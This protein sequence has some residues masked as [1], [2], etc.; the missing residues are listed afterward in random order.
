MSNIFFKPIK[1]RLDFG[2]SNN[3]VTE[4]KTP[5]FSWGAEHSG[6]NQ[7]QS[8]YK[9]EITCEDKVLFMSG[10]VKSDAQKHFCDDVDFESSKRY[11]WSVT[12]KDKEGNESLTETASF[13]YSNPDDIMAKWIRN[14]DYKNRR[15]VY[16]STKFTADKPVKR[17][18]LN[19]CGLGYHETYI[20]GRKTSNDCLC[21][22]TSCY[23]EMVYYT[24][25]EIPCDYFKDDNVIGIILA[26]GWR[27]NYGF[28]CEKLLQEYYIP[29][30]GDT[31]LMAQLD[32]FYEDGSTEHIITDENWLCQ[33]SPVEANLFDG[34][35]YDA[36]AEI[37]LWNINGLGKEAK[38]AILADSPTKTLHPQNF[39]AVKYHNKFTPVSIIRNADG[40]LCDFGVNMAGVCSIKIPEGKKSG[41]S[42]TIKVAERIDTDHN[43]FQD[44]LRGA[45]STDTY[46][47]SGEERGAIYTP[48]FTYHGFRYAQISGVDY[49]T[50]DMIWATDMYSDIDGKSFFKCGSPVVNAVQDAIVRTERNNVHHLFTDC[51]QRDER[52]AWMNDATVRFDQIPFN[53]DIGRLFPKIIRDVMAEQAQDG[54]ITCTAPLLYGYRP[55]DPICSA[56]IVAGL[57]AYRHTGN[58]EVLK[59]A[60]SSYK[61][62]NE[63]IKGLR[64][65]DGIITYTRYG[66][67]AAPVSGCVAPEDAHSAVT[68]GAI[69]STA[70]HF[71]NYKMLIQIAEILG[72]KD[73]IE[74]FRKES[75]AVKEAFNKKWVDKK[76]GKVDNGSMGCQAIALKTGILDKELSV[77]AAEILHDE[78][79]IKDYSFTTGNLNTKYM[80]D[81]LTM[82]GY[83]EDAWKLISKTSYPSL[84]FMLANGATT[85]W[86]RFEDKENSQMNSHDHPMYGAAGSWLYEGLA[87]IKEINEG[88]SHFVVEPCFPENLR[89]AEAK[90]DTIKGDVYVYWTNKEG[91]IILFVTVPFGCSAT[92]KFNGEEKLCGSGNHIFKN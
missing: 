68:S 73:D 37:P 74:Y 66:D 54:G 84:G 15:A 42:V 38:N 35:T 20:N 69:M 31:A 22:P 9:I 63:C 44:T 23:N 83:H 24:V 55:S 59:E 41:D 46:I 88:F 82:Y 29:F 33:D 50:E 4:N 85:V 58:K 39:E 14:E 5:V 26:D 81:V 2:S 16:F 47:C 12:L 51:P 36:R 17:A 19:T 10:W 78:L 64:E 13:V 80:Y 65:D 71:Y 62:W 52:M 28:W 72:Q 18:V 49:L 48:R 11:F 30:I 27:A 7:R 89:Y 1:L 21:P 87:G 25:D 76:T 79:T 92:I 56:Y 40:F 57:Q 86:E 90:V 77:K 60:Y 3:C 34:E 75:E 45:K 8:E 32:I 70:F 53:F 6:E 43:L 67:W 91:K 61:A